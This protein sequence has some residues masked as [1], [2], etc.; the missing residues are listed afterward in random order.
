MP[1][2]EPDDK[3]LPPVADRKAIADQQVE[4]FKQEIYGH[5]LNLRRLEAVPVA[6]RGDQD[7]GQIQ[8]AQDAIGL[9]K[10]AVDTTQR[11][12]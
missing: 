9:L 8:S 4:R 11:Q 7:A 10:V 3:Y 2:T 1:F 12:V 5:V 6:A